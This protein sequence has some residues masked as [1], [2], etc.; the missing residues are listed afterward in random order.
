[1]S[2]NQGSK[3]I[4]IFNNVTGKSVN[5]IK[6]Y[7]QIDKAMLKIQCEKFCK[8]GGADAQSRAEQNNT[9]MCTCLAKS[10][11]ISAHPK[12]LTHCSEYTLMA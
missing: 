10:L 8:A 3:Q 7:S 2:W 11:T 12:L 6:E 4:T 5:V 9:V 1:M